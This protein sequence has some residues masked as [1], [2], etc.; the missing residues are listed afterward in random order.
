MIAEKKEKRKK[1]GR[2]RIGKRFESDWS[3]YRN[4]RYVAILQSLRNE[5]PLFRFVR[6]A[7]S[8]KWSIR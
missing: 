6:G 2:I 4:G 7:I 8:E 5:V 3:D 1:E